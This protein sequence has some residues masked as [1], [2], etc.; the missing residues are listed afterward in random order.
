MNIK[1]CPLLFDRTDSGNDLLIL[2]LE[3]YTLFTNGIIYLAIAVF[4]RHS[5]YRYRYMLQMFQQAGYK[6]HEY[7]KWLSRSFFTK[8]VTP[9]HI[10]FNIL[11]LILTYFISK[12]ITLTSGAIIIGIFSLFWFI[13]TSRYNPEKEKKPIVYTPRMI[14]LAV[15]GLILLFFF[16]LVLIDF[17]GRLLQFRDFAEPFVDRD[18]YFLAFGL[19]MVDIFVPAV[20][21][22]MGWVLKPV[23]KYVHNSFKRQ[24][25][26]KL[27]SMP[28]LKVVAITGSY[29]KTSTK[30]A[31][32]TF[33]KERYN[34]CTTPGSYNTPMGICK[35]VN[36]QLEAG[37]SVLILEMGARYKGNIEELCKLATPDIS[38]V[39]NVGI[40]HLETF[41][42]K[43]N[44]A[45]EKGALARRLRAGGTLILNGD[46]PLVSQMG[47]ERDDITRIFVGSSGSIRAA[48]IRAG[49]DGTS[50]EMEWMDEKGSL[51]QSQTV[52]TRLLGRHNIQNLLLAAGVARELGL[53]PETVA[54]AATKLEPVEHRLELK[55]RGGL[56]VIDDAFNSN[57][58]GAKNAVEIL[59]EFSGGRKFIITPGMIELGELEKEKNEE[60][61]RNIGK[62]KIDTVLLVGKER[63][64][65]ILE[66]IRSTPEGREKDIRVVDSLFEANDIL[67]TEAEDGDVV[68]YENDLPDSYNA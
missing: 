13:S 15:P 30:F 46:D 61:G 55:R 31:I 34:V 48:N 50:F 26:K 51:V 28:E 47:S 10:Y 4:V 39:T 16:W 25:K 36:N 40:A 49:A 37:H 7:V 67:D 59:S 52:R 12:H 3:I 35:V 1:D 24:A 54:I 56:T 65:P 5:L 43:E 58:V 44:I 41:G 42:S 32:D 21:W 11:I 2:I 18:P 38:V 63:T 57:P 33:L 14:R 66:G 68:L 53:R 29:G 45:W 8:V 27:A 19:V 17:G 9:E 20:V 6:T 64:K 62:S 60:F 23:E 22:A